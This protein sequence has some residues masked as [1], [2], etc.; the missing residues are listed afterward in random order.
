M[1]FYN[2]VKPTD[3]ELRVR[4]ELVRRLQDKVQRQWRDA[5]IL[6]FG[7]FMSGLCLPTADMDLVFCSKDFQRGGWPKYATKKFLYQFRN[8]LAHNRIA[9]DEIDVISR[10]KVPIIKYIDRE[11]GIRVDIS[12][13][14]LSGVQA[15]DTF[16]RWKREYPA[17]PILAML[18]KHYLAMRGLNEPVN[19]GLGGFSVIAL[20][21]SLLQLMPQSQSRNMVPEHHLGEVLMEFLDLYGNQFDY[22][23]VAIQLD[24]PAYVPKVS[25]PLPPPPPPRGGVS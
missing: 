3:F 16:L 4:A 21:V 20:V 12:F 22:E 5:D 8:F 2:H 17:M 25:R 24:P 11:T 10:A 15:I 18:V 14:N 1:D 19:G 13:E 9:L 6:P 7:S 23:N